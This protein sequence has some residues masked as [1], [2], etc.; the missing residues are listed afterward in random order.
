MMLLNGVMLKRF[1]KLYIICQIAKKTLVEGWLNSFLMARRGIH[2]AC[3]CTVYN[4]T[5]E[6]LISCETRMI[7]C[8]LIEARKVRCRYG[9]VTT[10]ELYVSI[11]EYN[12]LLN[13]LIFD[14]AYG[15]QTLSS[16]LWTLGKMQKLQPVTYSHISHKKLLVAFLL[17]NSQLA[18]QQATNR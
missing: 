1:N 14:R 8:S 2:S 3:T 16:L 5:I 6:T 10:Q 18:S 15:N 4:P 9:L 17:L 13:G 11:L 7:Q 12:E